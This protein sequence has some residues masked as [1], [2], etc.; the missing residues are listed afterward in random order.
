MVGALK[1][2]SRR[3]LAHSAV[4]VTHYHGH[5]RTQCIAISRDST[6]SDGQKMAGAWCVVA[7]QDNGRVEVRYRKV[8]AAIAVEVQ[9]G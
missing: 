7:Q 1:A 9:A 8:L 2:V 5:C 6:K 4:T 3:H